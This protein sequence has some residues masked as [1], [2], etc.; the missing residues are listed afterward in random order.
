MTTHDR[1]IFDLCARLRRLAEDIEESNG[2]KNHI[3]PVY[4]MRLKHN[5]LQYLAPELWAAFHRVMSRRALG[6]FV[7]E[8][9]SCI[10]S[11]PSEHKAVGYRR[12]SEIIREIHRII[13]TDLKQP[14][15]ETVRLLTEYE[16]HVLNASNKPTAIESEEVKTA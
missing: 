11:V 16:Q 12:Q 7:R 4:E 8:L 3:M 13:V 14:N 9:L 2:D 5:Q 15:S 10:D 6:L 1:L